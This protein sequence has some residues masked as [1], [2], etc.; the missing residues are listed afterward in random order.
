MVYILGIITLVVIFIV[1]AAIMSTI[2]NMI[3]EQCPF[4]KECDANKDY[5]DYIPTCQDPKYNTS[6]SN[7]N[8]LL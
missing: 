8:S 7:I 6:S 3:C 5:P 4:K 2:H 1:M